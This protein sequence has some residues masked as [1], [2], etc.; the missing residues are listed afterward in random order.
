VIMVTHDPGAAAVADRV[1]MLRDGGVVHDGASETA[2]DLLDL[3]KQ[4][5]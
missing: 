1:V 2:E 3:M 5:A 4:V